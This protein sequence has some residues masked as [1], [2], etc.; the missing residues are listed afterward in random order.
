MLYYVGQVLGEFF[1][2]NREGKL[3]LRKYGITPVMTVQQKHRFA[4]SFS[5]S[6]EFKNVSGVKKQEVHK[7][8]H[9]D[10]VTIR[11]AYFY[12]W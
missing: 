1:C 9:I 8:V 12:E 6:V 11:V 5:D 4:S 3:E 2:I 10:N 7:E